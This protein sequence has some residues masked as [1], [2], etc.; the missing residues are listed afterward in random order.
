M[1]PLSHNVRVVLAVIA[2]LIVVN[3]IVAYIK[4]EE[5]NK[6]NENMENTDNLS[7]AAFMP[8]QAIAVSLRTVAQLPISDYSII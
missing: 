6:R 4:N 5:W 7:G 1:Q 8:S 3:I 2:I